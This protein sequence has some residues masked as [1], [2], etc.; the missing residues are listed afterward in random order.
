MVSRFSCIIC[1][2]VWVPGFLREIT[3]SVP[4]RL[5][6]HKTKLKFRV[7]NLDRHFRRSRLCLWGPGWP[8]QSHSIGSKTVFGSIFVH[9]H[10]RAYYTADANYILSFTFTITLQGRCIII[11]TLERNKLRDLEMKQ[12]GGQSVVV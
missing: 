10:Y 9:Y 2:G 6:K 8:D 7:L 1:L 11:S 12:L 4:L 5:K 3:V